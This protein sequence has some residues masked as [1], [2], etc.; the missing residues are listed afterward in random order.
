MPNLDSGTEEVFPDSDTDVFRAIASYHGLPYLDKTAAPANFEDDEGPTDE[1]LAA[2]DALDAIDAGHNEIGESL[3]DTDPEDMDQE[4]DTPISEDPSEDNEPKGRTMLRKVH[5][6]KMGLEKDER[7]LLKWQY[8]NA[9]ETEKIE[10][11]RSLAVLNEERGGGPGYAIPTG[12]S[13]GVSGGLGGYTFR[14]IKPT[15]SGYNVALSGGDVSIEVDGNQVIG[16]DGMTDIDEISHYISD[17][18]IAALIILTERSKSIPNGVVSLG[19]LKPII[20]KKLQNNPQLIEDIKESLKMG[21]TGSRSITDAGDIGEDKSFEQFVNRLL[22]EDFAK[23][24]VPVGSFNE[25]KKLL[26]SMDATVIENAQKIDLGQQ[27]SLNEEKA[28]QPVYN[29]LTILRNYRQMYDKELP[30]ADSQSDSPAQAYGQGA[31]LVQSRTAEINSQPVAN[32]VPLEN[33]PGVGGDIDE[34]LEDAPSAV[35]TGITSNSGRKEAS[36]GDQ[37]SPNAAKA[38]LDNSSSSILS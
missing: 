34:K 1:E 2:I 32:P 14:T 12:E 16:V 3:K 25:A 18:Q 20:D 15:D 31:N 37:P 21:P 17:E 24:A 33:R 27:L 19:Q 30:E 38:V 36:Q 8:P 26:Q 28:A 35:G 13:A 10:G 29:L 7:G 22:K 9:L 6:D 23:G 4:I 5:P 11:D